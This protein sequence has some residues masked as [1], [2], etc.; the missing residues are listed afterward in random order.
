MCTVF[1]LYGIFPSVLSI[2]YCTKTQA[3][4][5]G[6]HQDCSVHVLHFSP[7]TSPHLDLAPFPVNGLLCFPQPWNG[8][9][10]LNHCF[11]LWVKGILLNKI[12]MIF[13]V[14]F[15]SLNLPS[16]TRDCYE[17]VSYVTLFFLAL[18]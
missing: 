12:T 8:L 16:L 5:A 15:F 7:L 6:I 18:T 14:S 4:R 17:I 1:Y 3:L 9:F 10:L 2:L 13:L 11:I